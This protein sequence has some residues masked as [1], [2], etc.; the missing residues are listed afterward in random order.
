M[1]TSTKFRYYSPL[2]FGILLLI[3]VCCNKDDDG[4]EIV[5]DIDGNVYHTIT[6]GNQIWMAENLKVTKYRNGDPIQFV[7]DNSAW[8]NLTNGG[9]SI[10]KNNPDTVEIYGNLYN[11]IAVSDSRN[12][13]PVGWH[14]P[15]DSELQE[16]IDFLGGE[17]VAGGKMKEIG[18]AHWS[19]PNTG[20]SNTSGFNALPGGVRA[21]NG[22]FIY[23][24]LSGN[25]WSSD[26]F[27]TG[28][29]KYFYLMN[30]DAKAIRS[31][32]NKI[33]GLSVRCIKD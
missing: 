8:A 3:G 19:F 21:S 24:G 5:T 32:A 4:S 17:D 20:A 29:A 1:E 13:C 30:T 33:S 7:T 27:S 25:F 14:V 11:W 10:Y 31:N 23:L 22:G 28:N 9:Y 26:D 2:L 18:Y 15:D 6:I 12:I 16:L